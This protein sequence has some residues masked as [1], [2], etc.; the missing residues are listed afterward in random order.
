MGND[1]NIDA[2]K[3]KIDPALWRRMRA[4]AMYQGLKI[5]EWLAEAIEKKLATEKKHEK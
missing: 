5:H 1:S 4:S 3:N 2:V